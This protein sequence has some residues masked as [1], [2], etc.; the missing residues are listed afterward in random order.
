[1]WYH[2]R[3]LE[4]FETSCFGRMENFLVF[5]IAVQCLEEVQKKPTG[6]FYETQLKNNN[7]SPSN[8]SYNAVYR[9]LC[10]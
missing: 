7:S 2:Q 5:H 1:M 6:F 9:T 4:T 8:V 10:C 3:H